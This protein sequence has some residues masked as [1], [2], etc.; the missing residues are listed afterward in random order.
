M[1]EFEVLSSSDIGQSMGSIL[2]DRH[3]CVEAHTAQVDVVKEEYSPYMHQVGRIA[4]EEVFMWS[5]T[6]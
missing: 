1:K 6:G 3:S 2:S 4:T 5:G